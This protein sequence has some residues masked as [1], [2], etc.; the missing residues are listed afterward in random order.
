M[1]ELIESEMQTELYV[2]KLCTFISI[3]N[4]LKILLILVKARFREIG[5]STDLP[6]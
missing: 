6:F 5:I 2:I 4:G 1:F 3:L